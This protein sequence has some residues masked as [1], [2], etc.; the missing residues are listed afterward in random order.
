M[1][2]MSVERTVV[3]SKGKGLSF[4]KAAGNGG[5]GEAAVLPIVECLNCCAEKWLIG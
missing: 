3:L 2:E 1:L 4:F 5:Q